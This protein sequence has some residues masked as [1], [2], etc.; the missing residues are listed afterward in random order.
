MNITN[1]YNFKVTSKKTNVRKRKKKDQRIID[2]KSIIDASLK[3]RF[4][5][6]EN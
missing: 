4:H 3:Q 1:L 6:K 2:L 5:I